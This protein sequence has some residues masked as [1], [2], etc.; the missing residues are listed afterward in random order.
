MLRKKSKFIRKD[1]DFLGRTKIDRRKRLP[2]GKANEFDA[3]KEEHYNNK[4]GIG[5]RIWQIT[6]VDVTKQTITMDLSLD[7]QWCDPKI[8]ENEKVA[9]GTTR[10]TYTKEEFVETLAGPD[11][12]WPQFR[13]INGIVTDSAKSSSLEFA[14]IYP[15]ECTGF[16]P[17]RGKGHID[18]EYRTEQTFREPLTAYRFPFDTQNFGIEVGLFPTNAKWAQYSFIHNQRTFPNGGTSRIGTNQIAADNSAIPA[19]TVGKHLHTHVVPSKGWEARA[20]CIS[21]FAFYP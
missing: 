13:F 12:L 9:K 6:A 17:F 5:L 7:F 20:R 4:M 8:L 14:H 18:G 10:L 2:L 19:W 3:I 21:S 11:K 1:G 16:N 15:P